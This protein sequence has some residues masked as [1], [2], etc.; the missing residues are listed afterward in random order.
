[1]KRLE[2]V[3]TPSLLMYHLAPSVLTDLT[4][5][6]LFNVMCKSQSL[7]CLGTRHNWPPARKGAPEKGRNDKCMSW[8]YSRR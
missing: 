5:T 7:W 6:A 2:N 4:L 3:D 8:G 1:M